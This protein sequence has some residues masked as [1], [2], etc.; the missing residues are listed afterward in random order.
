MARERR[1]KVVEGAKFEDTRLT[2]VTEVEP[3]VSPSGRLRRRILCKCDCGK[4]K[5]IL[6]Q[7]ILN[8]HTISCGCLGAERTRERC[9]KHGL[10]THNKQHPLY[11][12]WKAMKRRCDNPNSREYKWYGARGIKVCEEWRDPKV[13]FDWALSNGYQAGLEIDRIDNNGNYEPGNCR[14]T[15]HTINNRNKRDNHI[16]TIGEETRCITAWAEEA[17]IRRST[18]YSRIIGLGWEAERALMAPI[19]KMNALY[20][21]NGRSQTLKDWEAETGIPYA[22]LYR[23]IHK[24]AWNIEDALT[25]PINISKRNGHYARK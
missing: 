3:S 17:G 5:V 15:T 9:T 13:F 22:T 19:K 21:L 23:R 11:A 1:Y 24:L 4:E 25:T 20:S 6:L 10:T 14:F 12:V 2:A 16:V 8:G 7:N 18:L